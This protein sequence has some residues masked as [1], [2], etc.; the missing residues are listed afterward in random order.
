VESLQAFSLV[1]KLVYVN[2]SLS[3]QLEE[4]QA[5]ILIQVIHQRN[6]GYGAGLNPALQEVSDADGL[7]LVCNPD[8]VIL[9]HEA[10]EDFWGLVNDNRSVGLVVP[11]FVDAQMRPVSSCRKFYSLVSFLLVNDLW[12][13]NRNPKA[14][15]GH[16]PTCS[17]GSRGHWK[18]PKAPRR[19]HGLSRS[20]NERPSAF[21]RTVLLVVRR[22]GLVCT[23]VAG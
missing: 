18:L 19:S 8:V 11:A 9:N 6:R 23:H 17:V 15:E 5:G 7:V 21:R 4:P 12:L 16:Y 14:C 10:F 1:K 3:D 13:R 2:H 20:W 22:C